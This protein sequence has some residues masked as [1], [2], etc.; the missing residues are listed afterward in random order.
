[1]TATTIDQG[2][3]RT[4]ADCALE[5]RSGIVTAV[6]GKLKRLFCV[7][8]G[9]LIFAT[10]NV[11]EEQ[12]SEMLVRERLVTVGAL[13]GA[14]RSSDRLGVKLTRL[15]IDESIVEEPLLLPVLEQHVRELLF[16]TLDWTDGESTLARGRPD[17]DGEVTTRLSCVP[18]LFEYVFE[19]PAKLEEICARIGSLLDGC[20][21][22]KTMDELVAGT[23]GDEELKWRTL[24][25]MLLLGVVEPSTTRR[26]AEEEAVSREDVLAQLRGVENADYYTVLGLGPTVSQSR[27]REAYYVLA[28]R[29]HPDRF[30][31]GPLEALREQ[32][33]GYFATVTEA[34]NTLYNP[35]L[36]AAYDE[37][38]ASGGKEK[39]AAQGAAYLARENFRRGKALISKGRFRD[40]VTSL[41]NAV[42]LD[43]RNATYRLE[44][45]QL[46]ARNPRLRK[47]AEEQLI[48]V[49]RIDP[50]L[51]DGYL[52]LGELY[53][54]TQRKDDAIRLFQDVLR[55]EPGHVEATERLR[56]LGIR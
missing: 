27:I 11:I 46:L 14:Q 16:A 18:L 8:D 15:L 22:T 5:K 13:A 24:Y 31:T 35:R 32:V 34:Y 33:E 20:N 55:W 3:A 50:S 29:F 39:E 47:Q 54:K 44:L 53:L 6:R 4:L 37:Q 51:Y 28:R 45:G 42:Q 26:E 41:E 30:R 49:N 38:R 2:L 7:E 52:A 19:R 23:P 48:E 10:S 17:L 9:L 1:M 21:G 25:G 43:G 36:R 12:F 40:A 56:E